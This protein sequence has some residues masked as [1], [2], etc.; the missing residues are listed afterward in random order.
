RLQNGD[1]CTDPD[2]MKS[3]ALNYVKELFCSRQH[4]CNNNNEDEV[5]SLD[6]SA[7]MELVKPVT[8]KEVYHAL[9]STKSYKAPGPMVFNVSSSNFF[10]KR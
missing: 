5:A 9:M 1:W 7:I 10:G 2:L 3:E 8:K 6:D 4:I